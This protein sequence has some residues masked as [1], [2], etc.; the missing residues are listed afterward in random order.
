MKKYKK[1]EQVIVWYDKYFFVWE[2]DYDLLK[3]MPNILKK[4]TLVGLPGV[5]YEDENS[6]MP[7]VWYSWI[8]LPIRFGW[9]DEEREDKG[10][11]WFT[12]IESI[13]PGNQFIGGVK[14]KV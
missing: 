6:D 1:G 12:S 8:D 7:L 5:I 3:K 9:I 14:E 2:E 13:E 10:R 4:D 11:F